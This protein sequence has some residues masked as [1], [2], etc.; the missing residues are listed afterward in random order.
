MKV[1]ITGATGQLGRL[2]IEALA[3]RAPKVNVV[4]LAR[5][6]AKAADL[7]VEVRRAD[8]RD[9]ASFDTAL[10]GIEV[11]ALISSS[12]FHDRVGQHRTVIEA[13]RAADV[14]H[15]I[16][17]S[18][19][20]ADTS[21]LMV[22][23]DHRDTEALITAS[24][25]SYTILRNPWYT[26]NWTASLAAAIE[27]GALIGCAGN[28]LVSP[29]TRLDLAEALAAAIAG[30]GREN[31]TYELGCDTPFTLA[32]LAAEVSAQTG[33]TIPYHDLPKDDYISIL[34][35][36]GLPPGLPEVIADADARAAEGWLLDRSRSLSALIGRP[37][38]SLRDAVRAALA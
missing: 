11:L 19:L 31:T 13:A 3:V 12:D 2:A 28:A 24:G 17:T 25:L 33:R 7:G 20:K 27:A 32:D 14:K 23:P 36:F 10:Q 37:T 34:A 18:I 16:Y 6:P 22:A 21:P 4:A 30:A 5:D 35:G 29:A 8:Y 15:I 26:E 1:S 38:T 9:R